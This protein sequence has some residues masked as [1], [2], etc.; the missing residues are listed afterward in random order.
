MSLFSTYNHDY[1]Q[2]LLLFAYAL[3]ISHVKHISKVSNYK[4]TAKYIYEY[5]S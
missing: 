2:W 1:Q 4:Y 5:I 3:A